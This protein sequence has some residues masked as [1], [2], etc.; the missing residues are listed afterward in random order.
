MKS[1]P[2]GRGGDGQGIGFRMHTSAPTLPN[3]VTSRAGH[4]AEGPGG[5]EDGVPG[6]FLV[7]GRPVSEA[8]KMVMQPDDEVRLETPGGGYGAPA[9]PAGE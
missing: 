9:V 7:N 1:G 3:A 5:G 8:R 6:R 4:A 2:G